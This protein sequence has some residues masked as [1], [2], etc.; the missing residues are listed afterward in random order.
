MMTHGG[1]IM[2]E[3]SLMRNHGGDNVDEE[4]WRRNGG[5][6]KEET[7]LMRNHGGG[8]MEEEPWRRHH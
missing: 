4:S 2:E 8:I 7:S 6:I 3:T 5:G 1:G